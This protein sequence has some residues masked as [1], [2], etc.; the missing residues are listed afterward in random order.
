MVRTS[1]NDDASEAANEAQFKRRRENPIAVHPAVINHPVTGR[2]TLFVNSNW[3]KKFVDMDLGNCLL[4]ALFGW[5]KRPDF[6]VHFR[7]EIGSVE[8]FHNFETQ[9]YAVVG[10][11]PE[12]PAMQR[13]ITSDAEP[14]LDL[15]T[16]PEYL[17]QPNWTNLCQVAE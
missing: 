2:L 4:V 10:Y 9:R 6:R 17:R 15:A 3:T 13:G 16:V 11:A 12:Y 8:I 14:A 7:W 5:M 1:K